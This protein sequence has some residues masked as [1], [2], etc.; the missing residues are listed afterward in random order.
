[1]NEALRL[2][3]L[4][5]FSVGQAVA[6]LALLRRRFKPSTTLY[7]VK[8][9]RWYV[10]MLLLPVEWGLT[11]VL[12]ALRAGE[13]R[14]DWLAVRVSG[15]VVGLAGAALLVWASVRLGRFFVHEAAVAGD[16]ALVTSGP[17][18]LVR[19]P[20]YSGYLLLLLGSGVA[21]LNVWLLLLW[22]IALLGIPIQ[23][24]SEEQLLA[25]KFGHAI[26]F[27][28]VMLAEHKLNPDPVYLA[29]AEDAIGRL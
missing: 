10:P 23:A 5:L 9:W 7:R 28:E 8:G 17:Y 11:P 25:T 18:R 15:F 21:T 29:A 6:L 3:S 2:W 26:K 20:V 19:H 22:P 4:T 13:S 27:T 1:M 14:A 16:H 12:I 24:S